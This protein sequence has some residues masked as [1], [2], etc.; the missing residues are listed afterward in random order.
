MFEA[1]QHFSGR[2]RTNCLASC[3]WHT[4]GHTD[5]GLMGLESTWANDYEGQVVAMTNRL[6]VRKEFKVFIC[7]CNY[8]N[9]PP[10]QTHWVNDL[11]FHFL[12]YKTSRYIEKGEGRKRYMFAVFICMYLWKAW[13]R[14]ANNVMGGSCMYEPRTATVRMCTEAWCK[15]SLCY[16]EQ[17]THSNRSQSQYRLMP[18]SEWIVFSD[19]LTGVH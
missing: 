3:T 19:W 14:I 4:S 2:T 17:W 9:I 8:F 16:C 6:I 5:C 1:E 7:S 15:R 18:W 11:V 13:N 12:F 10:I